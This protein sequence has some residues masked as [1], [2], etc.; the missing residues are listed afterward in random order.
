MID[1]LDLYRRLSYDLIQ[2]INP[3]NSLLYDV[4]SVASYSSAGI[5]EYGHSKDHPD[6]EQ[7]NMGILMKSSRNT[8]MLLCLKE[9]FKA[10]GNL[11]RR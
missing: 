7:V 2:N 6:L 10:S 8:P 9:L 5:L 11:F 3:G 1:R 4:T